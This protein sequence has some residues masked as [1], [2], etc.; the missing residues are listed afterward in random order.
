M[1]TQIWLCGAEALLLMTAIQSCTPAGAAGPHAVLPCAPLGPWAAAWRAALAAACTCA[2]AVCARRALG[3]LAAAVRAARAGPPICAPAPWAPAPPAAEALRCCAVAAPS[4]ADEFVRLL[5]GDAPPA[6]PRPATAA[7]AVA[8]AALARAASIY[9]P[10]TPGS[11]LTPV[12]IK[13]NGGWWM[14][15]VGW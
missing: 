4:A 1:R 2:A 9:T 15:N 12:G 7:A 14:A 5:R 3:R 11:T 6:P 8:G 10:Y 13:V